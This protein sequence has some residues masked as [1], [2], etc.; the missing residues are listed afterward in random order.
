MVFRKAVLETGIWLIFV[1][2]RAAVQP[3]FG[4]LANVFGRRWVALV[5]V[6]FYTLG[7]AICGAANNGATFIAGRTVQGIGSGG[8]YIIT[9]IIISDL[10]SA[11][12]R[13]KYIAVVL[14]TYTSGLAIGPWLGGEI[15][16]VTTW[17]WVFY[18]NLPVSRSSVRLG[19]LCLW[20]RVQLS[21]SFASRL[22][23][24]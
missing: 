20:L 14:L 19:N 1:V 13:G 16:A 23:A 11:R 6:M 3:L 21:N 2:S 7:S 24:W 18:L 10:V 12:E 4:Q 17:R 8:I 9:D 22:A 15:V 5:I